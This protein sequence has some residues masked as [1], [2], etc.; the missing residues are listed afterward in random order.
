MDKKSKGL[1]LSDWA[2]FL[3]RSC[4]PLMF[5][6][7][8]I[9]CQ[10]YPGVGLF[11][12]FPKLLPSAVWPVS[13]PGSCQFPH[14]CCQHTFHGLSL[15][16][17]GRP[18]DYRSCSQSQG[19]QLLSGHRYPPCLGHTFQLAIQT[20]HANILHTSS[21]TLSFAP[22][23]NVALGVTGNNIVFIWQTRWYN[24]FI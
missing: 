24:L 13:L 1:G 16:H 3:K 20:A 10:Y 8:F 2:V 22:S 23:S 6:E 15:C 9:R 12:I 5:K 18:D 4:L 14:Q 21:F 7:H 11:K 17:S 19:S